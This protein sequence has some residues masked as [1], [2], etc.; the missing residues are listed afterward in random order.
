MTKEAKAHSPNTTEGA[1][2]D[3]IYDRLLAERERKEERKVSEKV[4]QKR[5]EESPGIEGE[6]GTIK[7][8]SQMSEM[9]G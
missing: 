7:R 2:V 6:D 1:L 3:H 8:E 5:E 9:L 4:D